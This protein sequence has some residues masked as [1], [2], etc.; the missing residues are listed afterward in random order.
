VRP[1]AARGAAAKA[2][3][4]AITLVSFLTPVFYHNTVLSATMG[5]VFG[6]ILLS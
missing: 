6:I 4:K 3:A 1:S 2:T 5:V